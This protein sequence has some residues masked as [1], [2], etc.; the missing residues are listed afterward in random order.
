[1][2]SLT[3]DKIDHGAK[4]T[5]GGVLCLKDF[6]N[7]AYWAEQQLIASFDA[8]LQKYKDE[9]KSEVNGNALCCAVSDAE[10]EMEAKYAAAVNMLMGVEK[11]L[12]FVNKTENYFIIESVREVLEEFLP[13]GHVWESLITLDEYI[14]KPLFPADRIEETKSNVWAIVIGI[15]LVIVMLL[16][17]F[18]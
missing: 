16:L 2:E 12:L 18:K 9:F 13:D 4:T 3:I 11:H 8:D 17:L 14:A 15:A 7:G 5:P 6:A 1:M 10:A